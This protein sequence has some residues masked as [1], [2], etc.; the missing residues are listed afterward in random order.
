[1]KK[2]S[3]SD[4]EQS[5]LEASLV[6]ARQLRPYY[7]R[8]L[9]ALTPIAADGLGTVAVDAAWRLYLDFEWFGS[10]SLEERAGL[11]AAHEIEH[12][13]R[14]HMRRSQPFTDKAA[15]LLATDCEINDDLGPNESLPL[16]GV[17][18]KTIGQP[19]GL[20]A[21]EYYDEL[22]ESSSCSCAGGSGAGVPLIGECS[23]GDAPGV[24]S[25]EAKSL[26]E[27]V[28]ADVR[29]HIAAGRGAV[30]SGIRI[31]ADS[32]ATPRQVITWPR[33]FRAALARARTL[34]TTR[35]RDDWSWARPARRP[36]AVL[37]PGSIR[38]M[39]RLG[40]VIDTSGSMR[41]AG[42][43]IL[44]V[45]NSILKSHGSIRVW[46]VDTEVRV[47][48]R[49]RRG[50][51]YRGG[52]GTDLRAT[53]SEACAASDIVVIVSDGDTLWDSVAPPCPVI[54][55]TW[56]SGHLPNWAIRVEINASGAA[57]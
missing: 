3:I 28:A 35:G 20:L 36:S 54:G 1:M 46:Q 34:S 29:E 31:W 41:N 52:G 38:W 12:L 33:L 22:R 48:A 56:P 47:R 51:E 45:V 27:A 10:L 49:L 25:A 42:G 2:R 50:Q 26:R 9:A 37:R 18:P 55:V 53:L 7:G 40:L 30:P 17:Y 14:D 4:A 19:D 21:E 16:H 24:S 5:L 8:A 6:A 15:W 13:L 32:L 23:D 44:S 43:D 57:T 11:L 39:P